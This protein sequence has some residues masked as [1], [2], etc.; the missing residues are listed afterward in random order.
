MNLRILVALVLAVIVLSAGELSAQS[1]SDITIWLMPNEP[2]AKSDV[3]GRTVEEMK[4]KIEDAVRDWGPK[5]SEV[6]LVNVTVP[7]LHQQL[8]ALNRPYVM[9]LWPLVKGQER[10]LKE[11]MKFAHEEHVHV[12][13]R[14]LD[15]TT[16][17]SEIREALENQSSP[18]IADQQPHPDV[19]Q[20]GTTW[21]AYFAKRGLL[22]SPDKKR[23]E[24]PDWKVVEQVRRQKTQETQEAPETLPFIV[25]MRVLYYWKR[26]P[27]QFAKTA[28]WKID[29][30]NWD[31]LLKSLND[32]M[33]EQS[34]ET[35]LPPLVFPVSAET[36]NV[37][38]D[39][40]PLV[41]A[42]GGEFL[43]PGGTTIDLTSKAALKV[44]LLIRQYG[45]LVDSREYQ[46]WLFAFPEISPYEANNL[47]IQG[48]FGGC[49][50]PLP[51]LPRFY[52]EFHE[53]NPKADF[54]QCVDIAPL[55]C[56][57]I[58]GSDLMV[59]K[60]RRT[61]ELEDKSFKSALFLAAKDEDYV[62]HLAELGQMPAHL[63]D[64]GVAQALQRLKLSPAYQEHVK[65]VID[66]AR[67]RGREYAPSE[68]FP[69]VIES[70]ETRD[71]I[72]NVWR[73][74][75]EGSS[76]EQLAQ[77][78][79]VAQQSVNLRIG[80]NWPWI[81]WAVGVYGPLLVMF[82]F[83]GR[84]AARRLSK[85]KVQA[86]PLQ[87]EGCAAL[88]ADWKSLLENCKESRQRIIVAILFGLIC[89]LV[90]PLSIIYF[91]WD[92]LLRVVVLLP[93]LLWVF[94]PRLA[95]YLF[96]RSYEWIRDFFRRGPPPPT[97]PL[98]PSKT[99]E[100]NQEDGPGRTPLDHR[101]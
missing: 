19:I 95:W 1:D 33:R 65:Q 77:A 71:Q 90:R 40:V 28:D 35:R 38:H 16:A 9:P 45:R 83:G 85:R 75:S 41:W 93:I 87:E 32:H 62:R 36:P 50:S 23:A 30:S 78:A 20:I 76:E 56:T 27:H 88:K 74:M 39:Y 80:T 92:L 89:W 51:F 49:I 101:I 72:Q 94:L 47:V 18:E 68:F 22:L 54:E 5:G 2:A 79:Y 81:L 43:R 82:F 67:N 4:S 15:W 98:D 59:T 34:V 73:R 61:S 60:R 7:S 64:L 26:L 17:F 10:V 100:V 46:Y 69:T 57:F 84:I 31:S 58:G 53:N 24:S 96:R 55:P 37:L 99:A 14:I 8:L 52:D 86:S 25:D 11:L 42:G 3:A 91:W 63:P 29:T 70:R 66:E 44:P 12:N 6:T 13:V 97:L 21:R 48:A